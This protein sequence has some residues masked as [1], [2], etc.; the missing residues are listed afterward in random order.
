[1]DR[2]L[3]AG[4]LLALDGPTPV[5]LEAIHTPGHAPGHLCFLAR[6]QRALMAGDMVASVGTILVEPRD[7]DMT[8]YLTSLE[9]M[10][11]LDSAQLLPAHGFPITQP[12]ERLRYYVAHRLM[13]E[14]R[15]HRAL[16]E[17]AREVSVD[18]LL[19]S[20]Y[21]DTPK[22]AWPLARL[23]AEAHLIKLAREG[24]AERRGERWLPA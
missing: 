18:E 5:T 4:E 9:A 1:V 16:S 20:A 13:R 11:A 23:A 19:P 22:V 24:K 10:D 7:G 15:V 17:L 14:A 2:A 3:D 8:Q 12:R 6:E 21:A